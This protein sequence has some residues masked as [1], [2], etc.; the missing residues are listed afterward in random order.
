[1]QYSINQTKEVNGKSMRSFNDNLNA[2]SA[3]QGNGREI[4]SSVLHQT[5]G[6]YKQP[7]TNQ[8]GANPSDK[9]S[10]F[11]SKNRIVFAKEEPS[12]SSKMTRNQIEA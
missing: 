5:A 12:T 8:N 4:D 2:F 3:L 1:M 9:T 6:N 7:N 10:P 11:L